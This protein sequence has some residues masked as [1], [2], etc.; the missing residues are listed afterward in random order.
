MDAREV[1]LNVNDENEIEYLYF[2]EKYIEEC[3]EYVTRVYVDAIYFG[4]GHDWSF[5][6]NLKSDP[7]IIIK[8]LNGLLGTNFILPTPAK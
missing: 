1:V 6:F 4:G 2:H 3:C 8:Q 5:H 7:K